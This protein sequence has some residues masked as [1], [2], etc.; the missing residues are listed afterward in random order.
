[1]SVRPLPKK[2]SISKAGKI[3]KAATQTHSSCRVAL[4]GFGTVGRAVARIICENKDSGL[5]LTHI[6]NR[7]VERK[8]QPWVPSDVIWTDDIDSVLNSDSN[9]II[10]LIGGLNPAEQIV[11]RALESG[12]SVVTA[13]KQLIARHGPDLLQLAA[14]NGCRLEFGASVAG[15]VP[16]LPALRTGLCGDRLHGIAGI[17]NGT[18]NY[19]LSRIENARIPFSEALEEAQARGYAEADASE[20]LDGGDARAKLAILALAGLNSR[21]VPESVRARTIRAIDAV[22]FD[23]AAELGCTIRQISRA[24]LKEGKLFADVGPCLVPANSPFGRVQRNLNLVLTSGQYGGDMAFLG[25][26]AGGDPTAVAVVSDLIFVAQTISAG[27][28]ENVASSVS[29]VDITNDFETA[30]YLR[31]FVRDQPGIVA[32]LAQILAEHHLNIDS[33]LQKPGCEKSALPFV[34]TLEPCRDSMLHP[35]LEKMAGLDFAI[36]PCL[37]LP[38][39]R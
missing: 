2:P 32:R 23:Y 1:M 25:A 19:I 24:D 12:K 11:R 21:V 8:K 17:L 36:R 31:F 22:D 34:I 13:N 14:R 35:A 20:D 39:L 18:C 6:C 26:G 28:T 5:R 7:K 37:C 3:P 10:E 33:L 29:A 16:V 9:I 4:I 38:I 30:W 15:G 27:S